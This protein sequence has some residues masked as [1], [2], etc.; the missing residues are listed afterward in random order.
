MDIYLPG[1]LP[2]AQR[3]ERSTSLATFVVIV[4]VVEVAVVAV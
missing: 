2:I 4:V 3:V 1:D